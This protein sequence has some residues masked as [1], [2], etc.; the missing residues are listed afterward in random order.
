MRSLLIPLSLL[1]VLLVGCTPKKIPG[2]DLD[3][4]SET[5]QII[6]VLQKY[7]VAVEHKDLDTLLKMADPSFRDDGGSVNP[8]DDLDYAGLKTRLPERLAKVT[9][10]KL[11][12]TIKRIELDEEEKFAR[13]TYSYQLTFKVPDYTTRTQSENDIKQMVLKRDG[14]DGWK[15]ASGI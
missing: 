4:T 14:S 10:L 8:E 9:D 5:R 15:I 2:T 11:D 12:L 7:R 13:V 3:D 1:A 6:D